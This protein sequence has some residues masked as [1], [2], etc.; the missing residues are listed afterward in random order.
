MADYVNDRLEPET[1]AQLIDLCQ[2]GWDLLTNVQPNGSPAPLQLFGQDA[3][4]LLN[5]EQR[6]KLVP[7]GLKTLM[8]ANTQSTF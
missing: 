1:Q 5:A 2:K 7:L 3:L 8:A 6:S 4:T